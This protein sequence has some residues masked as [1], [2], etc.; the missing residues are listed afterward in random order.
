MTKLLRKIMLCLLGLASALAA[1]GGLELILMS[2]ESLGGYFTLSL[3]EG[4]LL[5][6]IF[7]FVFGSADGILLSDRSRAI[8]GGIS[9][10]II[11]LFAGGLITVLVQGLLTA[12]FNTELFSRTT[13]NSTVLPLVRSLGWAVLGAVIGAV[14]GFRTFSARRAGVGLAGGVL[15]GLLGG[16]VLEL[17]GRYLNYGLIAR[18]SGLILMGVCIG[19]FYSLFES[20][21]S[22]ALIKVLTGAIRGKEYLLVSKKTIIGSTKKSA[23]VLKDYKYIKNE[24][25]MFIAGRDGVTIQSLEGPVLVNEQLVSEKLLRYEDVIE[26]GN[27][28]LV[29]LPVR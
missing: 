26:A 5:G 19:L 24:H 14:D 23:V 22:Y 7:G 3:T 15:G 16:L 18:G 6:L 12:F 10:A 8:S 11:G 13:E 2:G 25:F 4:L 29:F 1:W 9:G 21:R 17:A 20:W 27:F 28:R